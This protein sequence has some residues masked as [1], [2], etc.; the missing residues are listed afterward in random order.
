MQLKA[1][2][3][4]ASSFLKP[5]LSTDSVMPSKTEPF[6]ASIAAAASSLDLKAAPPLPFLATSA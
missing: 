2:G 1:Q 6:N 3:V 4:Q 5:Q